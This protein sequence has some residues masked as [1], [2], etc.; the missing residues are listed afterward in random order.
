VQRLVG[1]AAQ[2]EGVDH[3]VPAGSGARSSRRPIAVVASGAGGG[4]V[5]VQHQ[6]LI[7][8]NRTLGGPH[9]VEAAGERVRSGADAIWIVV[10]AARDHPATKLTTWAGLAHTWDGM[11]RRYADEPAPPDAFQ[12]A[13]MR[14][15]GALDRYRGLGVPVGGEVGDQDPFKA[16][17]AA[18]AQHPCEQVLISTLPAAVSHW[19]R[20]DLPSRVERKFHIPVTTV[21]APA[22]QRA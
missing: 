8:A 10:P 21:P 22:E 18:L 11:A 17:G 3:G 13:Q 7:V 4:G 12:L 1:L 15:E 19:L 6:I 16:I 9:L 2:E 14:L 5:V 20:V